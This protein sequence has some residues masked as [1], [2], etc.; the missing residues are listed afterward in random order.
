M[1]GLTDRLATTAGRRAPIPCRW[2]SHR[3][4]AAPEGRVFRRPR[5]RQAL[6]RARPPLDAACRKRDRFPPK[7]L[8]TKWE[9]LAMRGIGLFC[10]LGVSLTLVIAAFTDADAQTTALRGA[11]VI[12]GRGG[13]PIDNA[14]IV[15]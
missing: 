13:A 6:N 10:S 3:P 15:I 7:R 12:D 4:V 9:D 14:T 5:N 8:L 2:T 11:R 1:G